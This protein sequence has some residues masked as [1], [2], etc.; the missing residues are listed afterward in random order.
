MPN[1]SVDRAM[2]GVA[3]FAHGV[4]VQLNDDDFCPGIKEQF[5]RDSSHGAKTY[6]NT[7]LLSTTAHPTFAPLCRSQWF[8]QDHYNQNQPNNV[9]N[10][11][12]AFRVKKH[13]G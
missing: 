10:F 9:R 1:I 3:Q 8:Y 2:T 11:H 13:S 4:E 7:A 6:E 12:Q 5:M